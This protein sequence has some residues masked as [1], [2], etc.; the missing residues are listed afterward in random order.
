MNTKW[1]TDSYGNSVRLAATSTAKQTVTYGDNR[2][3]RDELESYIKERDIR[4]LMMNR[5]G[6]CG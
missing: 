6:V 3:W 4:S 1:T 5:H 2:G